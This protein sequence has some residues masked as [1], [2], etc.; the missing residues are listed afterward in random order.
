MCVS[1]C[2]CACVRVCVCV[3]V[4][5]REHAC[6]CACACVFVCV[7]ARACVWGVGVQ[8]VEISV[9]LSGKDVPH[10]GQIVNRLSGRE[11]ML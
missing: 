6:A 7:C 9:R 5:A 4:C 10:S 2:A 8:L 11:V 3:H 1:V